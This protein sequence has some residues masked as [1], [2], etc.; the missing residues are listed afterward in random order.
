MECPLVLMA[1][2]LGPALAGTGMQE[3]PRI[4]TRRTGMP[5]TKMLEGMAVRYH[6]HQRWE[7][8]GMGLLSMPW[9][10]MVLLLLKNPTPGP[11]TT[12]LPV[13]Q[14]E[15]MVVHNPVHSTPV[16]AGNTRL[17]RCANIRPI[18]RVP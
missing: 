17:N 6:R 16:I 10:T 3:Y 5:S 11:T 12:A 13:P 2:D 18:L 15:H 14:L 8:G 9:T 4:R 7:V 1:H